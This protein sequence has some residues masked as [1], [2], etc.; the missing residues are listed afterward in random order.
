[1]ITIYEVQD[2]EAEPKNRSL[3]EEELIKEYPKESEVVIRLFKKKDTGGVSLG[4]VMFFKC[5]KS[6][7]KSPIEDI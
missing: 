4:G 3:T 6:P 7:L 1:M 2:L 5:L